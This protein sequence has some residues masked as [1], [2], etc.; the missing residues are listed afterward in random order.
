MKKIEID[1]KKIEKSDI[2]LIVKALEQ[3]KVIAYPTDT[4]YGLGCVASKR[5]AIK[6][7]L[8][9]KKR[10]PGKS[11]LML[12]SSLSMAK[13][14]CRIN[15]KQ[16]AILKKYWPGPFTFILEGK[17]VL[18]LE[19][20]G[21]KESLALRLPKNGFLIKII[22]RAGEPLVSTSLNISGKESLDNLSGI[23]NYFE[24]D[25]PDLVI[26]A[27]EIKGRPSQIIDLRDAEDVK[28]IRK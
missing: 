15:K 12:V 7:I 5:K 16:E 4:I 14:Y 11:L 26:D 6:K 22:R 9:I 1:F 3:G 25:K 17:N 18:P 8:Q 19:V 2:G 24:K 23:E 10:K 27:G 28:T 21:E 13:K 20:R